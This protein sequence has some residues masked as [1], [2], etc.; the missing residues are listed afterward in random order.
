MTVAQPIICRAARFQP[1]VAA[2]VLKISIVRPFARR[3]LKAAKVYARETTFE[4]GTVVMHLNGMGAQRSSPLK[5]S[6]SWS[7]L[8]LNF[9]RC[10]PNSRSCRHLSSQNEKA[11]AKK[12]ETRAPIAHPPRHGGVDLAPG[13]THA[14]VDRAPLPAHNHHMVRFGSPPSPPAC[15]HRP[16]GTKSL[17]LLRARVL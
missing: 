14:G 6:A 3:C 13:A 9:R 15:R 12:C 4:R 7:R 5:R 11:M 2:G 17:W 10:H 1:H 16:S 8:P